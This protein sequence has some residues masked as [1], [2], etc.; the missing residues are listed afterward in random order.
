MI[1]KPFDKERSLK[2]GGN[3]TKNAFS[4]P[5]HPLLAIWVD[6]FSP[7][8]TPFLCLLSTLLHNTPTFVS[9]CSG[10]APG[11]SSVAE[12]QSD[13]AASRFHVSEG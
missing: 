7:P 2:A 5:M 13:C 6:A 12:Q 3:G 8:T 9:L 1:V 10:S 11:A 4:A